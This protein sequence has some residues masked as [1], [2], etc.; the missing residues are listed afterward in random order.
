MILGGGQFYMPFLCSK[1]LSVRQIR[2]LESRLLAIH[3]VEVRNGNATD[4]GCDSQGIHTGHAECLEIAT[5]RPSYW[6]N[7]PANAPT[8]KKRAGSSGGASG[9]RAFGRGSRISGA[10]PRKAVGKVWRCLF[11]YRQETRLGD[12]GGGS[13]TPLSLRK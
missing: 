12:Q 3:S 10:G 2:T 9:L 8:R 5:H 6:E 7:C 1:F 13:G 4:G 11:R